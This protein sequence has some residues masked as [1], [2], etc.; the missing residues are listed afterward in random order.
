MSVALNE[1]VSPVLSQRQFN[2][3]CVINRHV[4][5]FFVRVAHL[6]A[7]CDE[8]LETQLIFLH[9]EANSQ[10]IA[11]ALMGNVQSLVYQRSAI[12]HLLRFHRK[13]KNCVSIFIFMDLPPV[14]GYFL[15]HQ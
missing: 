11:A 12:H 3:F 15:N 10:L 2:W 6:A 8:G 9:Y 5:D 1:P 13:K 14:F 4:R 7:K